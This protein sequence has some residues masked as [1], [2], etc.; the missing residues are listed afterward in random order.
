MLP[1]NVDLPAPVS[2][3]ADL[4]S[5]FRPKWALCG[6]WAVDAWLGQQTRD[7]HDIDLAAFEHDQVAI[8]NHHPCLM[9]QGELLP[10]LLFDRFV[11][12]HMKSAV[13][14]VLATNFVKDHIYQERETLIR[15]SPVTFQ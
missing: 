11:N 2:R 5:G 14:S 10:A 15:L 7:H 12:D 4:M 13:I 8:Y 1:F 6:G 9:A 3:V